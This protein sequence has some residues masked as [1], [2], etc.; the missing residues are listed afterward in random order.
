M[1]NLF[2]VTI[3]STLSQDLFKITFR[4]WS[5]DAR[6]AMR[7]KTPFPNRTNYCWWFVEVEEIRA[8]SCKYI[9]GRNNPNP[10][11]GSGHLETEFIDFLVSLYWYGALHAVSDKILIKCYFNSI[12]LKVFVMAVS[13]ECR[14]DE[15]ESNQ[16]DRDKQGE[17][18]EISESEMHKLRGLRDVKRCW[19]TFLD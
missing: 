2:T 6:F 12:H 9:A 16:T 5:N 7:H 19:S 11:N 18:F 8:E 1:F 15:K 17:L 14:W 3:R 4:Y 13:E 10:H